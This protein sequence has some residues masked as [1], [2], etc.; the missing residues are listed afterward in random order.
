MSNVRRG[1]IGA[2]IAAAASA[3]F[4]ISMVGDMVIPAAVLGSLIGRRTGDS[5]AEVVFER[6]PSP[7]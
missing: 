6:P 7:Q 2:A 3:P 4:G 1:W 5:R